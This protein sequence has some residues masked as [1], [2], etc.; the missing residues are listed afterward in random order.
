MPHETTLKGKRK[1]TKILH[2]KLSYIF[3]GCCF[4][5]RKE[6]GPGQKEVVYANL[7]VECLKSRNISVEKEK[8]IKIYSKN[9]G[10]VVGIYRPDLVIDGKIL[11]EV[12]SSRVTL[13]QHEKQLYFYLRNSYYEVGYLVNFSTKKLYIKRIIYTNDKKPFL[14][15]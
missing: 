8:R 5:I 12:K 14:K 3:Q 2:K 13:K 6:Y 1:D 4:E 15:I 7:L 9:S 11:V 10:K